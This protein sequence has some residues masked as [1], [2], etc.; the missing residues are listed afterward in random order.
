MGRVIRQSRAHTQKLSKLK[1]LSG[2]LPVDV[3]SLGVPR[4][5]LVTYLLVIYIGKL[6]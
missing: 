1:A 2:C 6:T 3:G 4:E 5:I